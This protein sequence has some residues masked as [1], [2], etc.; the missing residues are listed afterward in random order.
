L[1]DSRAVSPGFVNWLGRGA[2]AALSLPA[3]TVAISLTGIGSLAR[4]VGH[5]VGAVVLSTLIVWAGPAQI[6]FYGGIAAGMAPLAVAAAVSL[7]SIRFLPMTISILPLLQGEAPGDRGPG[8]KLSL[9]WLLVA[10]HFVAV[11]VWTESL[12]RLPSVPAA[13]RL[14]FFLGFANACV[15]LSAI[16]TGIGYF[17][18]GALPLPLAAG[19][20]FMSPIFF[21]VSVAAGARR[22]EEWLA[23]VLGF[24]LEPAMRWLFGD[25]MDLLAVGIVGG[26]AAFLVQRLR[27]ARA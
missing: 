25:S 17:L 23:I 1:I 12:R 3:W 7:S 15:I 26:S 18:V 10:A 20:L 2:V 9:A 11:T 21:T 24:A 14:P 5:P 6:I 13:H 4:D 22:L 16:G 8:R 27:S 19:M